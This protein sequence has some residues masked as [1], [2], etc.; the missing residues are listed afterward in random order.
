VPTLSSLALFL[1]IPGE[2]SCCWVGS[3]AILGFTYAAK[4]SFVHSQNPENLAIILLIVPVFNQQ[5]K[6]SYSIKKIKRAVESAFNT[7]ELIVVNDGSTDNTLT[8][9]RGITLTDEHIRVLSYT[10]NR[11]K[12]YAVR[13]GV[14]HSHGDAVIFLDGDLD[15]S[16]KFNKGNT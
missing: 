14:L 15:I 1:I 10:P 12:G 16:T 7:Y 11:G 6:I 8:I 2:S 3:A 9:L 4:V 13:Q 5:R